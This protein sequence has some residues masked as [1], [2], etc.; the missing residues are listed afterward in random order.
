MSY[1]VHAENALLDGHWKHQLNTVSTS[2]TFGV[3]WDVICGHCEHPMRQQFGWNEPLCAGNQCPRCLAP[4]DTS[5][6][7]SAIIAFWL[8]R[9]S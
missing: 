9:P 2:E 7:A 1:Q 4:L 3:R 8:E 6:V 5:P